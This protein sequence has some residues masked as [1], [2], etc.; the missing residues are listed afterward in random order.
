MQRLRNKFKVVGDVIWVTLTKGKKTCID[1]KDWS[2]IKN[3]KWL[4]H[5]RRG[6]FYAATGS[7]GLTIHRLLLSG[8][9]ADHKDGDSLNNRRRNL[10]IATQR[11]NCANTRINSRNTSGFKGVSL[12]KRTNLWR[13]YIQSRPKNKS[14]IFFQIGEFTNKIDAAK[15]YNKAAISYFGKFAFLNPA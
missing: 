1:A 3:F 6:K 8:N 9:R 11:Q 13:A 7:K 15:A 10:R 2:I 14:K 12:N 4:A 5:N